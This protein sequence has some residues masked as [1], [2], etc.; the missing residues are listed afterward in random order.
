MLGSNYR[1]YSVGVM[2][3][4]PVNYVFKILYEVDYTY[5]LD[6]ITH[7]DVLCMESKE[8]LGQKDLHEKIFLQYR[9]ISN[10]KID[11]LQLTRVVMNSSQIDLE[12]TIVP[13]YDKIKFKKNLIKSEIKLLDQYLKELNEVLRRDIV[14]GRG[15][16]AVVYY[17]KRF[18]I[19]YTREKTKLEIR[20]SI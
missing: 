8:K 15:R 4:P 3:F 20:T 10:L 16:D 13:F 11:N 18:D 12:K 19:I 1:C 14:H 6:Q 2:V 5:R 7:A 17:Q 9:A